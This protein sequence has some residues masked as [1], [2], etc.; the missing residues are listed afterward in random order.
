MF[1]FNFN[2]ILSFVKSIFLLILI[3]NSKNWAI[4]NKVIKIFILIVNYKNLYK[5]IT[6]I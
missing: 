4:F 6:L 3:F 5:N 1:N 2:V